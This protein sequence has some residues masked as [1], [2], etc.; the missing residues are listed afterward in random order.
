MEPGDTF[1][2]HSLLS[3]GS[4]RNASRDFRR[5]V[6]THIVRSDVEGTWHGRD[7]PANRSWIPLRGTAVS[8]GH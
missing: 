7:E 2:F 8:A 5:V 6:S 3:H 4:V 1:L